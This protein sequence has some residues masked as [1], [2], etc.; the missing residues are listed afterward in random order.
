MRRKISKK[1]AKHKD[2]KLGLVSINITRPF[3]RSL[4]GNKV[5]IRL[6][7][8]HTYKTWLLPLPGRDHT[9]SALESWRK[10][11]ELGTGLKLKAA[12]ANNALEL[13]MVIDK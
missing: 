11:E 2:K 4:R 9:P 10:Q 5:L 13:K 6:I 8:N 1:L 3:P 7:N 12:R